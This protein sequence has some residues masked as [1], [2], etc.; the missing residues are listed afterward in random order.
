MKNLIKKCVPNI[1]RLPRSKPFKEGLNVI[2]LPS[3]MFKF[4]AWE[5]QGLDPW[6]KYR[7]IIR[8]PLFNIGWF[9]SSIPD[10]LTD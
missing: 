1:D 3:F 8:T 6:N 9:D 7:W 5:V 4:N 10:S 2:L